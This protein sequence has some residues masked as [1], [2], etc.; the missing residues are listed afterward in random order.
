MRK[1]ILSFLALVISFTGAYFAWVYR[2]DVH[3]WALLRGYT[4]S[5]QIAD[6]SDRL[7][8][9]DYGERL[10]YI[11]DPQ[12]LGPAEFNESCPDKE[13]SI[14]L[15]CYN[16]RQIYVFDVDDPR[17][18]SVEEVTSA[19]EMLHAA[20]ERFS[21]KRLKELQGWLEVTRR[22]LND[23]RV[24]KT[25]QS[26]EDAGVEDIYNEIHSILGTEVRDLP[27]YLEEHYKEFF[28]DRSIVVTMSESYEEVF[29]S[30][31]TQVEEIDKQLAVLRFEIDQAESALTAL[32]V[33]LDAQRVVLDGLLNAGNIE[34]Y[35]SR[36]PEFNRQTSAYNA[37]VQNVKD[38]VAEYN[39]LVIDRNELSL[40]KNN[41]VESIDSNPAPVEQAI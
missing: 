5:T 21:D 29:T 25:F 24:E 22:E 12:L 39:K 33:S 4:P 30:I 28:T 41:L 7:A 26:Y 34:V 1:G 31:E 9:T 37:E 11:N 23:E 8:F 10:F 35:N 6:I 36:V 20:Y 19:H 16:G 38:S 32:S 40:E 15:G 3:D 17:I 13:A 27:D 14:I 2:Y 18:E